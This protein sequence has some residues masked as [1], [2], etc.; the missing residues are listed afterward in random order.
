MRTRDRY[1]IIVAL[2]VVSLL[3]VV[4]RG[5]QASDEEDKQRIMQVYSAK[6]AQYSKI[7]LSNDLSADVGAVDFSR[8]NDMISSP[9]KALFAKDAARAKRSGGMGKLDFDFLLNG[10]DNCGVPLKIVSLEKAG[11]GYVMKINNGCKKD[12]DYDPE[13]QLLLVNEAGKWVIDD[14]VYFLPDKTTL[15]GILK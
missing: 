6:F 3:A 11:N 5:A 12:K 15:Q 1:A 7:F 14:A 2:L 4:P 10:Q 8:K 13:Y 9:L